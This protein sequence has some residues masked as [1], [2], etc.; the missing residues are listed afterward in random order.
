MHVLLASD[1][2]PEA[3]DTARLLGRLPFDVK[4]LVTVVTALSTSQFEMLS[5][6]AGTKLLEV[7]R[8][9]AE[10]QFAEL[11][12]ILASATDRVDLVIARGHPRRLILKIAQEQQVDLIAMGARGHWAIHRAI[13]GSTTD[14]IANHAKCSVLVVRSN[15]PQALKENP[16]APLKVML[17]YDGSP[18]SQEALRQVS[19]FNWGDSTQLHV[20]MLLERPTLLPDDVVYDELTMSEQGKLLDQL[21]EAAAFQCPST[22]AVTETVHVGSA[23]RS[24]SEKHRNDLLFIG[25]TG[26]SAVVQLFLGSDSRYLLHHGECSI[27]IAR[28]TEWSET[29]SKH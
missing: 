19:Q 4:P 20:R 15:A 14:F 18:L 21:V 29:S 27:W 22:H 11:S 1:G 26:K 9:A 12:E 17:A 6:N 13:L 2:S 28:P 3:F 8:A 10:E 24:I 25:G 7:E 23:L 16:A 5:S